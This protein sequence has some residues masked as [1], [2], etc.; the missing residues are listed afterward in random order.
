MFID[1]YNSNQAKSQIVKGWHV[2]REGYR[3]TNIASHHVLGFLFKTAV[4]LYFIFCVLF[5][6]LRYAVLP[7]IDHYKGQVEQ[8]VSHAIGNPVS[9]RTIHASWRGLSPHLTLRD[10]VIRDK[11]GEQALS[12][13]QVSA[14][15]SWWSVGAADLRLHSL[16]L[17]R[18]DLDIARDKQGN[19]FVA[20]IQIDPKQKGDG[21]GLDWVLSQREIVIRD[22]WVRWND[23]MR[24]APE[25]VLNK[26]DFVLHNRWRNHR[27]GLRA[28]PPAEFAAPIDVRADFDHPAF[29]RKISDASQWTGTLYADWRDTDLAIWKTYFNYPFEVHQGKGSVRAWLNFDHAK[30]ADFTA[31]LTLSSVV[32]RLRKD[33]QL[34]NLVQVSG[35]ISAREDIGKSKLGLLSF[36]AHG[37]TIGVTDL[38]L[39]TS[40]GLKL[41]PT[42]IS[43]TYVEASGDKPESTEVKA[44]SLDLQTLAGFIGYLP[45]SETQRR[46]ASDFAPRGVL[47]DFSAEWQGA[48]PKIS[49]YKIKGQFVGLSM[50]PQLPRPAVP[51]SGSTPAQAAVPGIP[52]FDNLSGAVE[53]SDKGG[54]FSL[55]SRALMLQLP[56]YFAVPALP[57]DRLSMQAG[58]SWQDNSDFVFRIDRMAFAQPGVAGTLSGKHVMPTGRAAGAKQLGNIDLTARITEFDVKKIG[59]YLPERTPEKLRQWLTGALEDGT[60]RDV[61][62]VIKGDL[63]DFP[64]RTTP[65]GKP[66]GVFTVNGKIDK[67]RLIYAPGHFAA[68]GKSPLWPAMEEIKGVISIDRTRLEIKADSALTHGV[69]ITN[70]VATISDLGSGDSVLDVDG[71]AAGP[72]QQFIGFT[73]DSPVAQWIANFTEETKGTGDAKLA[74]KLQLPLARLLESKVDGTLAFSGNDVTLQSAIPPMLQ[75]GGDLRF[76]EKGFELKGIKANFLGGKTTVTGGTQQDGTIAVKA[77]GGVTSEG[78]RKTYPTPTVQRLMQHI[79]GGARYNALISVKNKKPEIVVESNMTGIGLDF[80]APL[81]KTAGE[82]MPLKFE[83]QGLASEDPLAARDEI[84]VSLGPLLS[85]RY[86]RQRAVEKGAPWVVLR[87]G[88][89]V[90]APAPQPDSGVIINVNMKS[91]NLDVWRASVGS[92]VVP[93][94]P[95]AATPATAAAPASANPSAVASAGTGTTGAVPRAGPAAGGIAAAPSNPHGIAQYIDPEMLAVRATELFVGGKKLD[96]VVVG[97]SHKKGDQQADQR[98]VWQANID[99]EQVSGYIEWTESR[100]GRGLGRVKARLASLIIP[101]SAATDVSELLEGK[102]EATQMPALDIIAENFQLFGKRFGQLELAA[103]NV[104]TPAGRDWQITKLMISNDDAVFKA[105]GKWSTANGQSM[106]SLTYAL[107]IANAGRLLERFGFANVLRN[108]KG[109]LD[110]DISWKGLP[111]SFDIPSMSGQLH[112]NMATGQFLKIDQTTANAS[113]LLG[114]LSLQSLPRLLVLDFRDVF[115]EGFSFDSVAATASIT[116]GVMKTDNFKMAGLNAAVLIDG[117]V[118]IAKESQNLHV[119]VIPDINAGAASLAYLLVNPVIGGVSFLAQ[120]FLRQP[121]ARALTKEFEITGPW[122]TPAIKQLERKTA[123]APAAAPANQQLSPG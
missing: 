70:A 53:A 74:L 52:G 82:S 110:G 118:D 26:V 104:R 9:I 90:N 25:L 40:D 30:V 3:V 120:L 95:T 15:V 41:P 2:L 81:R 16:E 102:N 43:E 59:Q 49:A 79:T 114:V 58:W 68:D 80:P 23:A 122:K 106:S 66:R 54:T 5:L 115:S 69:A 109:K 32:A 22:G 24:N 18:P 4:A 100:S 44:T 93:V 13:P 103:N 98:G 108:G 72:L 37:H 38:S 89:G 86:T 48:Y 56:G 10:V 73:N 60:A 29:A 61:A 19:L 33:L 101:Q 17:V 51:K 92:I 28:T 62:V 78:L 57:F 8:I 111:F 94:A 116:Q 121:L 99:S 63:A 96:N 77:E 55:D 35:R 87:G 91:I 21:R 97:A 6:A 76:Y 31:D 64:F 117:S 14:T 85:A 107:D 113:K 65:Q 27:V 45:L 119:V 84:K 123:P 42:T 88:I 46:M 34:L 39:E 83:L 71:N 112:L 105:Q 7:N 11:D 75:T 12:L 1:H 20:G 36:G 67:G 47:K 50:K